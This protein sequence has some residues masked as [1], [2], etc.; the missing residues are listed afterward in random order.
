[1]FYDF[2]KYFSLQTPIL[3][4]TNRHYI[5]QGGL[6][7]LVNQSVYWVL[8]KYKICLDISVVQI[9]TKADAN[10]S[11]FKPL[12]TAIIN[13]HV[14]KLIYLFQKNLTLPS[15]SIELLP[16]KL[17][18]HMIQQHIN[19][20]KPQRLIIINICIFLFLIKYQYCRIKRS[21]TN[22]S[23]HKNLHLFCDFY[24]ILKIMLSS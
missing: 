19:Q 16:T 2:V 18:S 20:I 3:Q 21:T 17:A 9:L 12:I 13:M 10:N 24:N 22:Y 11:F 14:T 6:I 15:K 5:I 8:D 23:F 4:L 7:C 1:M